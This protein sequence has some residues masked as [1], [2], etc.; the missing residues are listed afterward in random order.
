MSV[1]KRAKITALGTYVPPRVLTN[2]E[3]EKM[4]DTTTEWILERTGIHE[5][6]LVEPGIAEMCIRDRSWGKTFPLR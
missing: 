2:Q 6:H 1:T 4:V 3:L 5:R